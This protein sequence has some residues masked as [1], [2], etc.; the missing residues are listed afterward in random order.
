MMSER[1][2]GIG[3]RFPIE[4]GG[5]VFAYRVGLISFFQNKFFFGV[6]KT[7]YSLIN[8]FCRF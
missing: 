6:Q 3:W 4:K 7:K 5:A 8:V 2:R 1:I